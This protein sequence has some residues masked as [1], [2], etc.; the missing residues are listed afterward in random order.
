LALQL[1]LEGVYLSL[2]RE[3]LRF[4]VARL[5]QQVG[6]FFYSLGQLRFW[7]DHLPSLE[8]GSEALAKGLQL[9]LL[10]LQFA[11][12]FLDQRAWVLLVQ[13]AHILQIVLDPELRQ[14]LRAVGGRVGCRDLHNI[15]VAHG[16]CAEPFGEVTVRLVDACV[17]LYLFQ[18]RARGQHLGLGIQVGA[19]A[20]HQRGKRP[21]RAQPHSCRGLHQNLCLCLVASLAKQHDCQRQ[22]DAQCDARRN[23]FPLAAQSV[24]KPL[25]GDHFLSLCPAFHRCE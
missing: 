20:A 5:L 15:R 25:D 18:Q 21:A 17:S 8:E 13:C 6:V 7:G 16:R 14:S 24:R 22:R 2:Q 11:V 3:A 9:L 1:F 23:P 19:A 4:Q 12:E 10:V